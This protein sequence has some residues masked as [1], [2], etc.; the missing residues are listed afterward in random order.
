MNDIA[1]QKVDVIVTE[2]DAGI[3]NTIASQLIE[4]GILDPLHTLRYWRLM[5]IQLKHFHQRIKVLSGKGN[6]I[7]GDA[8]LIIGLS[9][10]HS[11]ENT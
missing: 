7:L 9:T 10:V 3:A 6:H 2:L 1:R 8:I 5:Q 4:F 11:L